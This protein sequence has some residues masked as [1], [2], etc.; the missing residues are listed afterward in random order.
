MTKEEKMKLLVS[1][2]N[3]L[4]NRGKDNAN[5]IRKIDREIKKLNA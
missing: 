5:I 3:V 2:K 1:R 4:I